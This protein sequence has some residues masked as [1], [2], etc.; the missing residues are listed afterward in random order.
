MINNRKKQSLQGRD[1]EKS[2]VF[3][4]CFVED[5]IAEPKRGKV[6]LFVAELQNLDL[7]SC[8]GWKN[9]RRH[10]WFSCPFVEQ[11]RERK[12]FSKILK[13]VQSCGW[14]SC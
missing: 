13:D 7:T 3:V 12:E 5:G 8:C 4:L 11:G 2:R 14:G 6:I 10:P 9:G 1:R